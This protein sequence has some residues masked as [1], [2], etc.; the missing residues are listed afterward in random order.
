MLYL[1][2]THQIIVKRTAPVTP[3]NK[4][5]FQRTKGGASGTKRGARNDE[6]HAA[7]AIEL[8][9][10]DDLDRDFDRLNK[11]AKKEEV[12]N[13]FQDVSVFKI[14]CTDGEIVDVENDQ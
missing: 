8:S 4:T 5:A 6:H 9:S 1:T 13:H 10:G 3:K 11:K 2:E 14:E 7:T 12:D